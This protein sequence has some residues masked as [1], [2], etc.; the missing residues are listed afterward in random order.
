MTVHHVFAWS[1]NG[2]V[3]QVSPPAGSY[4]QPCIHP[5]G[6]RVLFCGG[7]FGP[8]GIWQVNLRTSR[9]ARLTSMVSGS[10]HAAYGVAGDRIVFASDRYANRG[11]DDMQDVLE[12]PHVSLGDGAQAHIF[13]MDLDGRRWRPLT[14]GPHRDESPA[15]NPE[16]TCVVFTSDRDGEPGIWTVTASEGDDEPA[17]LVTDVPAYDPAW[18]IDGATIYFRASVEGVDRLCAVPSNGGEWRP[19]AVEGEGDEPGGAGGPHPDPKGESLLAHCGAEGAETIYQFPLDG[20]EVRALRPPGFPVAL[21]PSRGR[22]G[23][24]VFDAP[25]E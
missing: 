15:L 8:P 14:S 24:V 1:P 12:R 23:V 22:N 13:L 18:S 19:L 16:G 21:H 10:W 9:T 6:V 5:G 2:D 17:P 11:A 25:V 20:G 7:A 3:R 4:H